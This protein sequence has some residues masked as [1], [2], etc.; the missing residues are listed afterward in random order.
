LALIPR[1][2]GISPGVDGHPRDLISL[3]ES[4]T[5][6]GMDG[7]ILREPDMPE[8]ALVTLARRL[9]PLLG[10][11]LILHARHPA[12]LKIASVAGWGLHLSES[13]DLPTARAQ[14]QGLLGVSCHTP[15]EL[16][17]A[18]AAGC[19]YAFL[20]PIYTPHSKP[21]DPRPTLGAAGFRKAIL[22]LKI[23]VFALGG[24]TPSGASSCRNAGAY[25]VATIGGL[26][27]PGALPEDCEASARKLRAAVQADG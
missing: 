8:R 12:G 13:A 15:K 19:D 21:D 25:G 23:P 20:S 27:P 4:A 5:R 6:G 1:L 17:Q 7:L 22:G 24:V 3:V 11:G 14:V 2:I 10:P 26:F 9:S 18:Q 16:Y